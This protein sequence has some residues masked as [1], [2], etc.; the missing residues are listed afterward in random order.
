[1]AAFKTSASQ[2][3]KD[4]TATPIPRTLAMIAQL[5]D[6]LE[7]HPCRRIEMFMALAGWDMDHLLTAHDH[8][9]GLPTL[10][11][12]AH[13]L[14]IHAHQTGLLTLLIETHLAIYDRQPELQSQKTQR[15]ETDPS[16]SRRH[17][18]V[19]GFVLKIYI[20]SRV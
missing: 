15:A 19:T 14:I 5:G 16:P 17:R 13:L 6:I 8:Q 2:K 20:I 10:R 12:E 4:A 1:M 3:A 11:L 18:E 9:T 7:E